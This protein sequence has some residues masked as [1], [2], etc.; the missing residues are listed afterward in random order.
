MYK[1]NKEQTVCF[2]GHRSQKL[3]WEFNEEDGRCKAMKLTLQKE[4]ENAIK[5]GFNTFLCGMAIGFD[6]ICAETVI[7]LK[8]KYADIKIIGALPCKTQDIKWSV[9]DRERYRY[10]LKCLDG[11]RCIYNEYIGPECM[12]ERNRF[13]VDNSALM[14]ALFNGLPGGTK[15][16]IDHARKQGLEIVIIKP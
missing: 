11:V 3:P 5:N 1:I 12:F 15:S 13:M 6:I 16:T 14:I 2:T 8:R 4:V 7:E 10:I 9:K